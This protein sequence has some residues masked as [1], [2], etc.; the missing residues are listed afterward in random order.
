LPDRSL[1]LRPMALRFIEKVRLNLQ[2]L[3]N[4]FKRLSSTQESD[5][6]LLNIKNVTMFS[7][8]SNNELAMRKVSRFYSLNMWL[9]NLYQVFI[10][11]NFTSNIGT[12]QNYNLST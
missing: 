8:Q 3:H 6:D 11:E 1:L 2:N 7:I 9:V 12:Y 4:F 5:V 10:F